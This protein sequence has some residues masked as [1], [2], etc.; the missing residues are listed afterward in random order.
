MG[1]PEEK[2]QAYLEQVAL[3]DLDFVDLYVV[4]YEDLPGYYQTAEPGRLDGRP[5]NL[6]PAYNTDIQKLRHELE[7]ALQNTEET[8]L[9]YDG[10][11]LRVSKAIT[12]RGETWAALR[13]IAERPPI[14]DNLG[15]TVPTVQTLRGLGARDG[16]ILI[17]G[18]TGQG[19]TTTANALLFDFLNRF[20]GVAFT[21][22][23]PV[24]YLLDGCHGDAGLCYQ[25]EVREEEDWAKYVKRALRWHP[26]YIMVGELRTPEAANQVL[27]AAN[28]GH[29]VITTMHAGS[30]EEGLDGLLQ[31][32]SK[33]IGQMA[34]TLLA[35]GLATIM[36]QSFLTHA[37]GTKLYVTESGNLGEP[38]RACIR[39]GNIGQVTTFVDQQEARRA[40]KI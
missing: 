24:E 27:R 38:V 3:R 31:L 34:P 40:A 33:A 11:R 5:K 14:L 7:T 10:M 2:F 39:S 29:L 32:A 15:L 28:S 19:K 26:R 23:D 8:N 30:L 17:C 6:P 4:L 35:S 21:I 16:L 13:R 18:G 36:H 1:Q 37:V 25:I 20:G 9:I 22:E 12:T